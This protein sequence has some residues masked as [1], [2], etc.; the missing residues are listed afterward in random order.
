[1]KDNKKVYSQPQ[2]TLLYMENQ[3]M[4]CSSVQPKQNG[5]IQTDNSYTPGGEHN[6]GSE[7][8]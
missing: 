7:E 8:W 1:M 2:T 5:S 3:E 4:I 6:G